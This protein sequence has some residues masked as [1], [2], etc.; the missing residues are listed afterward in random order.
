[1]DAALALAR[2]SEGLASPNPLV[3]CVIVKDG[4]QI[5]EGWHEY[6]R[7]DHA[8]VVALARAG[9]RAS[10]ATAYVTLEPCSHQGRTGP[11][12]D[13]LIRAGVARVVAATTDPNPLVSGQGLAKLRAAGIEVLTGIR[14]EP[15][16]RINDAFAKY[17]R[18][19]LPLVT[20]K[21]ALSIDGRIAPAPSLRPT[22]ATPFW[23]TN[24]DSRERV[25]Q[26]RHASDALFTGINTILDDDPLLTDRTGRPR[27]R[28]LL[29]VILDSN[30]RLPPSSK[31]VQSANE[32]VLVFC[33][34]PDPDHRRALESAGVRVEILEPDSAKQ[35]VSLKQGIA[36]L[37]QLQITSV[38][39]EA[40]ARINTS[41]F[42]EGLVD[43]LYLFCAPIRLSLGG[44]PFLHGIADETLADPLALN[45]LFRLDRIHQESVGP[46]TLYEGWRDDLWE[47]STDVI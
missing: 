35:G 20:L 25:Q 30:L 4:L 28:P 3:G 12:A 9:N 36:R 26:M 32:D 39:I 47:P 45:K 5:G 43:R 44:L 29:R 33:T 21:A 31:L 2:H 19:G 41:A 22:E 13:A 6:D 7:R 10:G 34:Q 15:A 1:M 38:M 16:R 11:C 14:E 17:I 23:L 46:D 18:T 8:E 37:G 27:R 42:C 40:G 24:K